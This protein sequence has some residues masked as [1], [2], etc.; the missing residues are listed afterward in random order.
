MPI[1]NT[2]TPV[3]SAQFFNTA[4]L[5]LAPPA[6]RLAHIN[7]LYPNLDA[8]LVKAEKAVESTAGT[9]SWAGLNWYEKAVFFLPPVGP[10]LGMAILSDNQQVHES[11]LLALNELKS[12][13]QF[14]SELEAEVAASRPDRPGVFS[15]GEDGCV[16][17]ETPRSS[18][19]VFSY[20]VDGC[21][22]TQ[23][24]APKPIVF[25]YGVNGCVQG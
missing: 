20:G 18:G 2:T 11:A 5:E 4:A 22:S 21:V 6:D 8:D 16:L 13:A 10:F 23:L 1:I 9:D 12:V 3:A 7:A 15:Y 14:R 17:E 19:R 25:S 24:P